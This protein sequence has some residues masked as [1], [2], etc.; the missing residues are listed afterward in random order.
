MHWKSYVSLVRLARRRLASYAD[1]V[2]FQ[3]QQAKMLGSYLDQHSV[4]LYQKHV[5]DLGSGL[6]GYALEWQRC[7]GYVVAFDLSVMSPTLRQAGIPS[8]YGDA[9]RLP[10]SSDIFDMVF[11]ASLIE[12]VPHPDCLVR[13]VRRVLRP[14]GICYLSFPP[15]YSPRGG[16]EFS[17]FHYLG[18]TLAIKLSRRDRKIPE[19]LRKYYDIRLSAPSFAATYKGWGLYQMTIARA[20][21]LIKESGLTIRH[22]GTR[23]VPVNLAAIPILGEILAWHVQMILEK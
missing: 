12:H 6:G 2:A 9:Q 20:R 1:Y 10:F 23:Y 4:T 14:G 21:R 22:I 11:C 3:R 5:L 8:L 7:G 16:H 15:F 19:W 17:P 18:E 13:E